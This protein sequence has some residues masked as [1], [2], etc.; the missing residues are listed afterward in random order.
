MNVLAP[1]ATGTKQPFVQ[2]APL[3]NR[4][5]FYAVPVVVLLVVVGAIL[6]FWSRGKFVGSGPAADASVI[7]QEKAPKD[8]PEAAN[9]SEAAEPLTVNDL[10]LVLP[11]MQ[12]SDSPKDNGRT[13]TTSA[14]PSGSRR[15]VPV[16]NRQGKDYGI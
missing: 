4:K 7:S 9:K 3:A 1:K 10:P 11:I 12:S 13:G 15:R 16:P 14:I 6:G 5:V 2:F 8:S